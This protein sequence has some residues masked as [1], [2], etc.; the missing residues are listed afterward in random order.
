[1]P[2]EAL[3]S[4]SNVFGRE[5]GIV[6]EVKSRS[7]IEY[8]VM[9]ACFPCINYC[10]SYSIYVA[11]LYVDCGPVYCMPACLP[12]VCLQSCNKQNDS[13]SSDCARGLNSTGR[14]GILGAYGL[15]STGRCE[16]SARAHFASYCQNVVGTRTVQFCRTCASTLLWN[17]FR[18]STA[19]RERCC[20]TS[21]IFS[22]R[23]V[24]P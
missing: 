4:R 22:E 16:S 11:T 21:D 2:E 1:M 9:R 5:S 24:S 23:V 12:C 20:S 10:R 6:I 15:K 3:T 7:R 14:R 19:E 18:K 17:L 13:E 8:I